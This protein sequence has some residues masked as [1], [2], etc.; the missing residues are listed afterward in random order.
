MMFGDDSMDTNNIFRGKLS[1][2]SEVPL[3]NQLVSIIK[4][5][6]SSGTLSV[7]SL[8]PSEAELC[9]IFEVSRSTVRQ[10]IG[11]LEAE[12]IVIRKQGRG[13]FVADPKMRKRAD[14]VYSFTSEIN[15]VGKTPSSTILEFEVIY[16]DDEIMRI[17]ELSGHNT[18][19][20]R[21]KRIRKVDGEP[22]ILETSYYP[23]YVYPKL[24]HTLL[25]THSIYSLLFEEGV[26]PFAAED[27]YSAISMSREDAE[28]LGCEKG[29]NALL[30]QRK[31]RTE[32]GEV[33]ELTKGVI[34]ADRVSLSVN[35]SRDGTSFKRV[36]D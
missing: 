6:I 18:Q 31:T 3:Y 14:N 10:A 2:D 32:S 27:T 25:E 4:R 16:P 19:V 11:A 26:V 17:L 13:T 12:G 15:A 23:T 30:L 5:S 36:V 24:S 35:L 28:L 20:Y 7:G 9:K 8:L 1:M 21:F 22:F 33:Y 34:R 29:A